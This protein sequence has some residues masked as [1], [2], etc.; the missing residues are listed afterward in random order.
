MDLALILRQGPTEV[1]TMGHLDS[2]ML[3]ERHYELTASERRFD[4][5][6]HGRQLK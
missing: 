5:A 1:E 2:V 4:A 3:L 6:M